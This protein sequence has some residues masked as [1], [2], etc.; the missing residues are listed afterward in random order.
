MHHEDPQT[1]ARH[2]ID[3]ERDCAAAGAAAGTAASESASAPAQPR[4]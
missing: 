2:I 1:V 3:F 4:C